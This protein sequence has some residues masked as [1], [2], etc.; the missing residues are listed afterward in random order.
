M[1]PLILLNTDI[2]GMQRL[3]SCWLMIIGDQ[4]PFKWLFDV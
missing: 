1:E 2:I 3:S 4:L